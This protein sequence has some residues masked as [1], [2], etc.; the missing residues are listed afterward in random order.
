[1]SVTGHSIISRRIQYKGQEM[2]FVI[3][4]EVDFTANE[5]IYRLCKGD[6][7]YF[8]STYFH[9]GSYPIPEGCEL[10][11]IISKESKNDNG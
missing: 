3:E 10:L 4:G 11:F 5:K 7:I 2:I 8:D 1:M 9:F 6:T